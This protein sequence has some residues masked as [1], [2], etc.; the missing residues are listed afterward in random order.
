M[1]RKLAIIGEGIGGRHD[2]VFGLRV[3]LLLLNEAEILASTDE[4]FLGSL[5]FRV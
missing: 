2:G 4:I 1:I 3:E 5:R